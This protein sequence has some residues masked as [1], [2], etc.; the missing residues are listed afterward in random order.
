MSNWIPVSERVPEQYERVIG[1][2]KEAETPDARIQVFKWWINDDREVSHW[3]PLPEP[4][5]D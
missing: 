4:P 5:N 1:F 3:M 2:F